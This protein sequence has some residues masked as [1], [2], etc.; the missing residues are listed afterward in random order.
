V[1]W[2]TRL[3]G[4]APALARLLGPFRRIGLPV[5]EWATAVALAIR[6]LPL[7]VDETRTLSAVHRLR[8]PYRP[9]G[10]RRLMRE[11][12]DLLTAELVVALRRAD[13]LAS[14]VDA[15]GGLGA[16]ADDPSGPGWRDAVALA[17]V[18]VAVA[19]IIVL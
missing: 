7:L 6:C 5:A 10:R 13:E 9:R 3:S 1:S 12:L 17:V 19:A 18:A 4:V 16:I 14:A 11:A 15:R 8:Q 2:T